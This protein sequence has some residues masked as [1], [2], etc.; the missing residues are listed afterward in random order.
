MFIQTL[1]VFLGQPQKYGVGC[2]KSMKTTVHPCPPRT[3]VEVAHRKICSY[4]KLAY[5][6]EKVLGCSKS[7]EWVVVVV[8]NL[9]K[10]LFD[11]P[12]PSGK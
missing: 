4:P 11:H 6:I 3:W 2:G 12:C 5:F 9:S 1:Y 10:P 7:M 8:E